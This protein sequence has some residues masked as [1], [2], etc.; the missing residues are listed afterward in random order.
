M[1]NKSRGKI[2]YTLHAIYTLPMIFLCVLIIILTEYSVGSAMKKE[3][4]KSLRSVSGNITQMLDL[5]YPG[6]YRLEGD[7]AYS[8]YKGDH[9]LTSDSALVDQIKDNTGLDVTLFYQDTRI[10]STIRDKNGQRLIGSAAPAMVLEN[11]L[12]G[13]TATFYDDTIIFGTHYFAYYTPLLNEDGSVAGMLFVGKPSDDVNAAVQQCVIPLLA[14]VL[15]VILI[16]TVSILIF[17]SKFVTDLLRIR[18]F[19]SEVSS[20]E[21]TAVLHKSVLQRNDE[22]RDIGFRAMNMQRS[23]CSLLEHDTLTQLYN[24]RFANRKLKEIMSKSLQNGTPFSIAMGDIDYFKKINDTYGHDGGDIVLQKIS[25]VLRN[26]MRLHGFVARWGGEEFFFVFD[27]EDGEAS[28][29]VLTELLQEIRELEI[30]YGEQHIKVTMTFGIACM[31]TDDM[32]ALIKIAD[33]KLYAGKE[34]GRNRIIV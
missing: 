9:N 15:L 25:E 13:R 12:K 4:E 2:A 18:V 32:D 30:P 10:L 22:L 20:G 16:I 6:D 26:K 19:L 14:A 24:R 33:E 27:H 29:Q 17:T 34:A 21:M 3:V 8:I 28:C 7:T 23:L 11:V 5:A 1:K 31:A